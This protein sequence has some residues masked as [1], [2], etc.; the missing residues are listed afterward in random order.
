MRNPW[1]GGKDLGEVVLYQRTNADRSAVHVLCFNTAPSYPQ[2]PD[3]ES[4]STDPLDSITVFVVFSVSAIGSP[5]GL[6][7]MQVVKFS[8]PPRKYSD[9]ASNAIKSLYFTPFIEAII[10][11]RQLF[12]ITRAINQ[13]RRQSTYKRNI[14]AHSCNHGFNEKAIN[15]HTLSVCL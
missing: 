13:Q 8:V 2:Y 11:T 7:S 10:L 9:N 14:E 5:K 3:F 12:N 1:R 15:I 6:C 4:R